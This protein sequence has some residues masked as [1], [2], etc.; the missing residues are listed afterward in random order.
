[1]SRQFGLYMA[2]KTAMKN[3]LI[4]LLDQTYPGANDFFDSPARSDG[5]QKW[6]DFVHAYWHV[7]RVRSKS[8]KAFTESYQNWRRRKS[9]NFSEEKA[10]KIHR[11]SSDL[12]A[13]F[14]KDDNTRTLVGR[15]WRC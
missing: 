1:M 13:V 7:D 5:S 3:N 4:A 6:V 10:E 15:L 14:P 8:L 11:L 9:Y 2:H 12:I